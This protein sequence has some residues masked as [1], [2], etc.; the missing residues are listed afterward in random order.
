MIK[1]EVTYTLANGGKLYFIGHAPAHVCKETG[2]QFF[3][4]ETVEHI[5]SLIKRGGKNSI[6]VHPKKKSYTKTFFYKAGPRPAR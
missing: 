4:P 2:E 1:A 6:L 3:F 5:Q